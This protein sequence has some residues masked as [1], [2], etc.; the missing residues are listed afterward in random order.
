MEY[1]KTA[2]YDK[3]KAHPLCSGC[4][5]MQSTDE[6][7]NV[8]EKQGKRCRTKNTAIS[9][10][11]TMFCMYRYLLVGGRMLV[12]SRIFFMNSPFWGKH[13]SS[14]QF[15][16][17]VLQIKELYCIKKSFHREITEITPRNIASSDNMRRQFVI[18]TQNMKS[19]WTNAR[20]IFLKNSSPTKQTAV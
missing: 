5:F 2:Y 1:Q 15:P 11:I 3:Q 6:L 4:A 12:P 7:W 9:S 13:D 8:W 20:N 14:F 19:R 18:F 16:L 10:E 17:S